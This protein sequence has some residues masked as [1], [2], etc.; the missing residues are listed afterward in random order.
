M[1]PDGS[2]DTKLGHPSRRTPTSSSRGLVGL[3]PDLRRIASWIARRT[4]RLHRTPVRSGSRP[5]YVLS[6]SRLVASSA[7]L[8]AGG[9]AY[10]LD[11]LT[12]GVFL[13]DQPTHR[14]SVGEDRCREAPLRRGKGWILPADAEGLCE[15]DAPLDFATV[16]LPDALLHEA[17]MER[18]ATIA[19]VVGTLDPLLA[20]M[21]AEAEGF[22]TG[23]TLYAETM[24]RALAAHLVRT[25]APAAPE[26]AA[27]DD[28]RLRS[29]SSTFARIWPTTC[30]WKGWQAW[31]RCRPRTSP[32][33][34]RRLRARHRSSSS[35]PNGWRRRW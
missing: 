29:R 35:S 18:G 20:S 8:P 1:R 10:A 24:A 33:P 19:P 3:S 15:Y 21:A 13:T 31:R 32:A 16:S 22:G 9:G 28:P 5:G 12:I 23:G 6:M 17:G 25:V 26:V 27:L 2:P 30:R 34:S 14:L 4:S 7:S 11:A